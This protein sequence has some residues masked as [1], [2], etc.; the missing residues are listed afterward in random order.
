MARE[1]GTSTALPKGSKAV[2]TRRAR[3]AASASLETKSTTPSRIET[4]RSSH[5]KMG[6]DMEGSAR[7]NV[8]FFVGRPFFPSGINAV[9]KLT[10]QQRLSGVKS[11]IFVGL[12]L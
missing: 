1:T 2:F 4:C 7:F 11:L 6:R 9:R 12:T 10:A 3:S 5:E 8:F